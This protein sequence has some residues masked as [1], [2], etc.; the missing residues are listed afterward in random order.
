MRHFNHTGIFENILEFNAELSTQLAA[1]TG[2][3]KW[4]LNRIQSKKHDENRGYAA[5]ILPILLQNNRANRLKLGEQDGVETLLKILSVSFIK[6]KFCL[7][8][9]N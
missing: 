9:S 5:E 4:L 6:Q 1:K 3:L 2:I 7:T 8:E